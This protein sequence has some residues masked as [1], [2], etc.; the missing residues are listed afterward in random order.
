MAFVDRLNRLLTEAD[1]GGMFDAAST[2]DV[3]KSRQR[4]KMVEKASDQAVRALEQIQRIMK[5]PDYRGDASFSA[6]LVQI[7]SIIVGLGPEGNMRRSMSSL[8]TLP[9]ETSK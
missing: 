3:A 7:D 2:V 6:L 1:D 8:L 9:P 4:A 5:S